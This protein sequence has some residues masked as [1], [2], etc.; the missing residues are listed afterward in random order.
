VEFAA[1][2]IALFEEFGTAALTGVGPNPVTSWN[3]KSVEPT[4]GPNVELA[5]LVRVVG[6][7]RLGYEST[8]GQR[9][10]IRADEGTPIEI[11]HR[12]RIGSRATFHTLQ[13]TSVTIGDDCRFGDGNVVHGPLTI[14][15]NFESADDC[16]VFQ[17]TI[18]DNVTVRL[19]ATIAGDFT[20]REGTVIPEYAVILTQEDADA[21][22]VL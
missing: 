19:G 18:E 15:N 14:G 5:E 8:V 3:P 17:A 12:A 6:D 21:L 7:V 4:L 2:N 11:G 9:T 13:G 16:V 22:P 1:G 10:S 20:I